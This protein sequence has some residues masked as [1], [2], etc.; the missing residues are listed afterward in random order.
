MRFGPAHP[1][2]EIQSTNGL[3]KTLGNMKAGANLVYNELLYPD[4]LHS[5]MNHTESYRPQKF[6]VKPSELKVDWDRIVL[7]SMHDK[8]PSTFLYG[9][10]CNRDLTNIP[11]SQV[12]RVKEFVAFLPS[13]HYMNILYLKAMSS[14]QSDGCAQQISQ[15]EFVKRCNL[16]G[17]TLWFLYEAVKAAIGSTLK[18]HC[19]SSFAHSS[20]LHTF[21]STF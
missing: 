18:F 19:L 9:I 1:P 5:F 12:P 10:F 4:K 15:S 17:E 13:R 6:A 7:L 3:E 11:L 21:T 2:G 8:L 20:C 14:Y 16:P